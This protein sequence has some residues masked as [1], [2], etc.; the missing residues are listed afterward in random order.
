MNANEQLL[1][2]QS[3]VNEPLKKAFSAL[4]TDKQLV[5]LQGGYNSMA[6]EFNN[7]SKITPDPLVTIVKPVP[8]SQQLADKYPLL[9]VDTN[10]LKN[11][12]DNELTTNYNPDNNNENDNNSKG[13]VKKISI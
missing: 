2:P 10:K 13:S 3:V 8:M 9:A 11:D 1:K 4:P 7:L 12:G 5:A 6:K